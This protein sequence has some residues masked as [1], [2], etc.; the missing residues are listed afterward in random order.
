M[1]FEL[2]T[3]NMQLSDLKQEIEVFD[4]FGAFTETHEAI[5]AFR[6]Q[7]LRHSV[8]ENRNFLTEISDI[9]NLVKYFYTSFEG[10]KPDTKPKGG[11]LNLV[12]GKSRAKEDKTRTFLNK[13]GKNIVILLS[14]NTGF[15]GGVLKN[16]FTDF[17]SFV[18]TNKADIAIVGKAGKIMYEE[19]MKINPIIPRQFSYFDL[20]DEKP[21]DS[22]ISKIISF[23]KDYD[24]IVVH[25]VQ[26]FSVLTQIPYN[27]NIAGEV[28]LLGEAEK[29]TLYIFE[30]SYEDILTFFET[31]IL[32]A[33][34]RQKV[35]EHQLARYGGKLVA[36]D[37]AVTSTKEESL[38]LEKKR[39]RLK[40]QIN[41]K[42][43]QE[44]FSALSVGAS[45][46]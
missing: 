42:K 15:Y 23:A 45:E 43:Q 6:I 37:D 26:F 12:K 29:S 13:N 11:L 38:K 21:E 46:E 10:K 17:V 35:Y 18:S 44:V 27:T 31:Q 28:G 2:A 7:H 41:D 34:F 22:D 24:S 19:E 16:L 25:Y 3:K 32:E 9:Y 4:T 5:A 8:V 33:I 30:P 14:S 40:K 20:D 1:H 39:L 36:M